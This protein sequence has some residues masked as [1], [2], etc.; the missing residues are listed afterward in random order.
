MGTTVKACFA[1]YAE[2]GED[3]R[4]CGECGAVQD[5]KVT[6]PAFAEPIE[7]SAS[8]GNRR[9][10]LLAFS[11]FGVG[12]AAIAALAFL[13]LSGSS[14]PGAVVR[15]TIES[16]GG[17]DR[18]GEAMA[19]TEEGTEP[20]DP[21]EADEAEDAT[22]ADAAGQIAD[23]LLLQP[24]T[25][26]FTTQLVSVSK[27]NPLDDSFEISRQGIGSSETH[28]VCVTPAIAENPRSIAFP[29]QPALACSAGSFDMSGGGYRSSLT[30]SFPQFGGRRPVTAT[31]T[32][33]RNGVSLNVS[34]RVPAQVVSGNFEQ[35]PE[36]LMQYRMQGY[37]AGPC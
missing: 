36:I 18:A 34:V 2:L 28:S 3:D 21:D 1:C 9:E 22:T 35:P 32:Y 5:A 20:E 23:G 37:L 24:G 17:G 29:F 26:Q 33:S 12:A 16:L 11:L 7:E 15:F 8:G 27:V 25:W 19:E 14:R 4:Y 30:C 31:G 13:V 10:R 6:S